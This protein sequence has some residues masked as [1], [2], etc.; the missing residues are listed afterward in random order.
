M[1][2]RNPTCCKRVRFWTG[3]DRSLTVY[4]V[5][6]DVQV[7]TNRKVGTCFTAFSIDPQSPNPT[8]LPRLCAAALCRHK[9]IT[10]KSAV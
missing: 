9:H 7:Q 6:A 3:R 10:A 2:D 8:D 5:V 1:L 4:A